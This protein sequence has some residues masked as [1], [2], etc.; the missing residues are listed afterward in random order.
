[1]EIDSKITVTQYITRIQKKIHFITH[2]SSGLRRFASPETKRFLWGALIRPL[3]DY[4]F[5]ILEDLTTKEK[6]QI[7][8]SLKKSIK[9]IIGIRKTVSNDIIQPIIGDL[10]EYCKN[11]AIIAKQKI[12]KRF[13][14]INY[15]SNIHLPQPCNHLNLIPLSYIKLVNLLNTQICNICNERLTWY[16]LGRHGIQIRNPSSVIEY[17]C[18]QWQSLSVYQGET[19]SKQKNLRTLENLE[20]NNQL[21]ITLINLYS[22]ISVPGAPSP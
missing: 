7:N 21:Q 16:H 8:T 14:K 19:K 20:W 6:L 2:Q 12:K 11:R 18:R 17:K 13:E 10:D 5:P 4:I 22:L 3:F 1:M 15:E 9:E